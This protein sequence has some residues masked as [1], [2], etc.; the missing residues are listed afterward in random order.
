MD[1]KSNFTEPLFR[2]WLSLGLHPVFVGKTYSVGE[3]K[4]ALTSAGFTVLETTAIIHN[5]RFIARRMIPL[6]RKAVPVRFDKLI[7]RC[8]AFL[9]SLANKKTKY[10]TGQFIA[11]KAVKYPD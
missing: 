6:I 11:A 4:Q 7:K 2:L 8:L 9:D 3:L 1:N 10:L 5:P